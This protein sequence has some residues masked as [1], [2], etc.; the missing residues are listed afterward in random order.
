[1]FIRTLDLIL[2]FV[3]V[4]LLGIAVYLNSNEI[5]F[6]FITPYRLLWLALLVSLT[7]TFAL[8]YILYKK[9]LR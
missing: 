3:T 5:F 9:K 7:H 6:E 8:K 2:S 1:M 4:C